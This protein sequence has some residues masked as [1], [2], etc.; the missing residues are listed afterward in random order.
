[1]HIR[2]IL[3]NPTS[4]G[5]HIRIEEFHYYRDYINGYSN[6]DMAIAFYI[7][8]TKKACT[9]NLMWLRFQN[10]SRLSLASTEVCGFEIINHKKDGWSQEERF[11]VSDFED[12]RVFFLCEKITEI[13]K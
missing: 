10:V 7:G 13:E 3:D 8:E 5:H 12:K 2:T 9:T 11:E 4:A 6:I 1:M